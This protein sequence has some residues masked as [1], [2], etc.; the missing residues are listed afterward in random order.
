MDLLIFDFAF[1]LDSKGLHSPLTFIYF[2]DVFTQSDLQINPR[3]IQARKALDQNHNHCVTTA[4]E[5]VLIEQEMICDFSGKVA[6]AWQTFKGIVECTL[7][8]RYLSNIMY[9]QNVY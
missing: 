7:R 5:A 9:E 3:T 4:N 8:C 2:T 6:E 1:R